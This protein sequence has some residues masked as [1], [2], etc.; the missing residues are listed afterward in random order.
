LLSRQCEA[1]LCQELTQVWS[2]DPEI[3]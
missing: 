2:A 3:V 1:H